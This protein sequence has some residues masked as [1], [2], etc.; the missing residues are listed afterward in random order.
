MNVSKIA[1][2]ILSLSMENAR[3]K[4]EGLLA[5]RKGLSEGHMKCKRQA[6][7]PCSHFS[8]VVGHFLDFSSHCGQ[9]EVSSF[10][11]SRHCPTLHFRQIYMLNFRE[12]NQIS[13]KKTWKCFRHSLH[14]I[15]GNQHPRSSASAQRYNLF[16][17]NALQTNLLNK[18]R[19]VFSQCMFS[20]LRMQK[21]YE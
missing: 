10:D 16:Q 8:S 18:T 17:F 12:K 9:L 4:M 13:E 3:G 1:R 21:E 14:G 15:C 20:S 2:G 19:N 5:L 11:L 7:G 6:L